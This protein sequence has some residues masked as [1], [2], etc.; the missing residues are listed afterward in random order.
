MLDLLAVKLQWNSGLDPSLVVRAPS[1]AQFGIFELVL[2]NSDGIY[3][4]PHRSIDSR[5]RGWQCEPHEA[6]LLFDYK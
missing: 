2:V 3:Q 4:E 1:T 5:D 6:K